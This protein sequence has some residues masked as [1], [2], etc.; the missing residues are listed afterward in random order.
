MSF[1]NLQLPAFLIADLYKK[2]L[3]ESIVED[4]SLSAAA[5][6]K[7]PASIK[8][9]GQNL[10]RIAVIVQYE[11]D[12]YLP[13]PALQFLANILKACN[14]NLADIS[15]INLNQQPV[16]LEKVNQVLDPV[17]LLLFGIDPMQLSISEPLEDFEIKAIGSLKTLMA[18]RLEAM[19]QNNEQGKLKKTKLWHCLKAIF[20][21][22]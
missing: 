15:I 19:N 22:A 21:V 18:P 16:T 1:S 13:E 9:L 6:M 8:Y 10:K 3:I 20:T 7:E 11:D 2:N 17:T 5:P 4:P 12:L 14:L